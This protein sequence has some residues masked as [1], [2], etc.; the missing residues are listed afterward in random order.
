[1]KG[2]TNEAE[3]KADVALS[4]E[5]EAKERVNHAGT[6][7]LTP[8]LTEGK[9][10]I[11]ALQLKGLRPYYENV[12]GVEI[13]DGLLDL[14]TQ[15]AFAQKAEEP[16]VKLSELNAALRSLR[17][18]VPGESEPLWRTPPGHERHDRCPA[19]D[20]SSSAIGNRDGRF[21]SGNRTDDQPPPDQDARR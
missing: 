19:S 8:L 21:P 6:I 18:D 9:L 2:L 13:K 10:E 1:V 20:R 11:E 16:D 4:F 15:F 14:T 3:K 7:Q 17:L 12:I 5:S